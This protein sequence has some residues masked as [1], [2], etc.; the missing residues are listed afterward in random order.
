M[1]TGGTAILRPM[2]KTQGLLM[3]DAKS[4]LGALLG[5]AQ[6]QQGGGAGGGL[7]AVL[8]G[9]L[10]QAQN[11]PQAGGG[12]LGDL[13]GKLAGG[14]SGAQGGLGDLLGKLTAGAGAAGAGGG[15]GGALGGML[16]QATGGLRDAANHAGQAVGQPNAV[17]DILAQITGGQGGDLVGKLRQMIEENPGMATAGLGGL[18][19]VVLGTGAGRSLATTAAKIGGLALIGGLAYSAWMNMQAGRDPLN[20]GE[21]QQIAAAPAGSGFEP[22]A[23]TNETAA[24]FI[25]AMIAAAAA[26]GQIDA[27]ERALILGSMQQAGFDSEANDWL[28]NEMAN[29]ATVE[30][31]VAAVD[32]SQELASQVYTAA[33]LAITPDKR[34]EQKFLL[35][36]SSGLELPDAVVAHIDASTDAAQQ[37]A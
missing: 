4:V 12:G 9:L 37:A 15:L 7:G 17:N 23:A 31:L 21:Q 30:D 2:V 14:A 29:P 5:G 11:N 22:E 36:L 19:S 32:G 3:F 1:R 20:R 28:H 18:A 34:A 27:A 10:N 6:Q 25:R 35:N 8:G 26:D 33:R 16:G 24:L 13:L